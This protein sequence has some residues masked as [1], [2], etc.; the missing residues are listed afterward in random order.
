MIV[1]AWIDYSSPFAYLGSTQIERVAA[2]HGARAIFRPF[3]LGAL[4]KAIGTPLV[5]LESFPPAK[6]RYYRLELE[7]WAR[8]WGVPFRFSTR[9][10]LRTVDALRL[11][12]LAPEEAR[13]PLVHAIMRAT[14]AEDRDPADPSVLRDACE[15]A[16]VDP[17]LLDR[18]ADGKHLLFEATDRARSIG[19]PGA[20]TFVV[21]TELFW[22]QDRLT[23][24]EDAL[25]G[26][27]APPLPSS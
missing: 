23:L 7:R 17:A 27:I 24:V 18:L 14:W 2:A 19:V 16:H 1:E 8:H 22:G 15:V 25:R 3:L 26:V 13:S 6:E 12:L 9:F 5:P 21:G 11:T 4:F 20:P 10:P